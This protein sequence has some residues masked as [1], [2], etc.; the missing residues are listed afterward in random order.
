MLCH[1]TVGA[2]YQLCHT[3]VDVILCHC[4]VRIRSSERSTLLAYFALPS[5]QMPWRHHACTGH[6][7]MCSTRGGVQLYARIADAWMEQLIADF[8]TDHWY[9]LDGYFDGGTGP[10][11]AAAAARRPATVRDAAPHDPVGA[12]LM[13]SLATPAALKQNNT[14]MLS[15]ACQAHFFSLDLRRVLSPAPYCAILKKGERC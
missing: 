5:R 8:G 13:R 6:M 4:L 3:T 15:C 12:V 1:T 11:R 9:Q 2:C 14:C 7:L 10:W